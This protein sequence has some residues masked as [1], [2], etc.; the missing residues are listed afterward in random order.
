MTNRGTDPLWLAQA[1][2]TA[3]PSLED[4]LEV[5]VAV[6]GG[7]IAGV[8]AALLLK[9]D[10]ARVAVLERGAIC[11]GAT[12][13]T[14][15]KV[16]ALQ[17]DQ[18][19]AHPQAARRRRGAHAYAQASLAGGR[20]RWTS[21]SARRAST[22]PGSAL[23]AFT[24]AGDEDQADAV[25][26]EAEPRRRGR[27]GRRTSSPR[28]RCRSPSRARSASTI[29]RSG[30]RALRPRPGGGRRRRR[31][32]RV[33]EHRGHRRRRG[34]AVPR[35]D[36]RRRDGHRRARRR[37]DELPAARPRP[38]L[39]AHGG[40]ALATSSPPAIR[41]EA[42]R[43]MLITAGEP[44]R[45][46]RPYPRDGETL[47]ARRRRGPPHRR[48]RRAARALRG[49]RGVRARALR[50]H[51]RP[52]PVVDAGRHAGRQAALRRPVHAGLQAPVRRRRLPE[53]GHDERHDRRRA[54]SPTGSPGARTL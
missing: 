40:D 8:T 52:V 9:R 38:V 48:R 39:R 53:V 22:A 41:G 16:C 54:C 37:R 49:A 43:G 32:R 1:E 26:Q 18:A 33:R 25:E 31:L 34:L 6:I 35:R 27:P 23:P 42:P 14:T 45:S 2:P 13:F 44:T 3:Y 12:G 10:G 28:R 20:A 29:R 51:R 5:D 47:G 17:A 4:D 15:A 19:L 24:Y 7:G 30:P 11:G 50:R 36:R 21:S 46:I